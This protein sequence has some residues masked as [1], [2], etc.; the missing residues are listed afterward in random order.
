MEKAIEIL[1][2]KILLLTSLG[3]EKEIFKTR[4]LILR[5]TINDLKR[6]L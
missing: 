5:D 4:V 1:E 2:N 6:E 3:G